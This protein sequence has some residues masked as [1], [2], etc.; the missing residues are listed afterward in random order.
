MP[1]TPMRTLEMALLGSVEV[2]LD[3]QELSFRTRK[4]LGLLAF[5]ALEPGM[6][7]RDR[8]AGL[9]WPD[10]APEAGRNSLRNTLSY[11]RET[12]GGEDH[13]RI[14]RQAVGLRLSSNIWVDVLHLEQAAKLVPEPKDV[15]PEELISKLEA[16][17]DSYRGAFMDGFALGEEGE[18][19][20][21]LAERREVCLR[22][23]QT[24][25]ERLAALQANAGQFKN[26]I[27]TA[28]RLVALDRL[29]EAGYRVLIGLQHASGD[30][31]GAIRSYEVL[32]NTL[33]NELDLE[34]SV[35][36]IALVER[37]RLE[38]P[39]PAAPR[40]PRVPSLPTLLLEGRMVGRV[41]EFV[42]LVEA[43]H[44]S[45]QGQTRFVSLSG[46]PGIGKTRLASEFLT[47][48]TSQGATVLRGR[49]FETGGG[50]AYQPITDAM[51]RWLRTEPDP[52]KVLRPIWLGEL[53]RLLPELL[54][55]VPDLPEPTTDEAVARTRLFE[56]VTRLGLNLAA[57]KP[58]VLFMDDLQWADQVSVEL[59][60]YAARR[61][62]EE[63]SPVL[64]VF[65]VRT[66]ALGQTPLQAWLTSLGR[67]IPSVTLELGSLSAEDTARLVEAIGGA[68]SEFS[69]WLYR[70][71]GGQ[72][73]FITETLKS[74]SERGLITPQSGGWQV[75]LEMTQKTT[76]PGVRS[77]V[78]SRLSRLSPEA[79]AIL[80]AGAVLGQGFDYAIFG[81]GFDFNVVTSMADLEERVALRALDELLRSRLILEAGAGYM[82]SH[83][84]IR[85][86][87]QDEAS[88]ARRRTYHRRAFEALSRTGAAHFALASH[89]AGAH[90]WPEAFSESILAGD[91]A[92]KVYAWRAA[93]E[94]YQ[95]ARAILR[96]GPDGVDVTQTVQLRDVGFL[97]S[98]IINRLQTL[99][100]SESIGEL[101]PEVIEL[102]R[103]TG[104][105]WLEA[106][107]L[108]FQAEWI[109]LDDHAEYEKLLNQAETIFKRIHDQEGLFSIEMDRIWDHR[110]NTITRYA[111]PIERLKKLLPLARELGGT[112]PAWTLN[113]L[114]EFHQ[115]AGD[116]KQAATYWRE[117]MAL[118]KETHN[119]TNAYHHENL[120]LC[121][122][123]IGELQ[124]ALPEF[125]AAHQIKTDIDDNP[126]WIG[127]AA[128]YRSY[129]LLEA[130]DLTGAHELVEHTISSGERAQPRFATEFCYALGLS[131]LAAG[132][133]AEARAALQAG[134]DVIAAPPESEQK[135][136]V[137]TA[138]T[139]LQ[140][141][142]IA[143]APEGERKI[144]GGSFS[145]FLEGQLCAAFALEGDWTNALAHAR[146]AVRWRFETHNERGLHAPRL[147]HWLETEALL[148]GGEVDLARESVKRLEAVVQPGERL[149]IPVLRARA[150][151]EAWDGNTDAALV[152]LKQ[153][154]SSA[155]SMGLPLEV[156]SLE[157]AIAELRSEKRKKT[158]KPVP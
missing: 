74:L 94:H 21:W 64:I 129:G 58:V 104:D 102:A 81:Q 12:L 107:A 17:S 31:A 69:G 22:H 30:R 55:R 10:A 137:H 77:V 128:A 116:W 122:L 87:A 24:A 126:V 132:R 123:N 111:D 19:D 119:D 57:R 90:M 14:E 83:D 40:A 148:R 109:A 146:N 32:Q 101:P 71:T 150:M 91:E 25:L 106:N 118:R 61:W 110:T 82:F 41:A 59:L 158:I 60:G 140:I 100:E 95:R 27:E 154:L 127:M 149:E 133:P 152:L 11:L 33:R 121:L 34:P 99:N 75:Q 23:A 143:P 97:Y 136:W 105:P 6:H 53:S 3:G 151:L 28:S 39:T 103:R 7:T 113:A 5:L 72:P 35:D 8:L 156:R 80:E 85:E 62:L 144:W 92:T 78:Q 46:E 54:E 112:H 157:V 147:K 96:D 67:E 108:R 131:H 138:S 86:T 139:V 49:A 155:A 36:T 26:A 47:W 45:A 120:G 88:E 50:L 89:A 153:A 145:D 48:A 68:N 13:L 56:A 76:A 70:E 135:I 130:G 84:K 42:K 66:E 115:N 16:A 18:F 1:E 9:F 134:L 65:T 93:L 38:I 142:R 124:A 15:K 117:A 29:N 79:R 141:V 43:Y 98:K 2:R 20:A 63:A 51:R 52:T 44:A 73:L 114:A 4:V 37:V 125:R